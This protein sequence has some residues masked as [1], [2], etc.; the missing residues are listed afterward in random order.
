MPTQSIVQERSEQFAIRIVKMYQYLSES[1]H[2]RTISKQVLR[3]GTSIGANITEALN[4]IS[5]KDFL[6]KMYIALK[7]CKETSYWLKLL[8]K[9]G[10]MSEAEYASIEAD[11]TE[12]GKMLRSITKTTA[13]S[14]T[15]NS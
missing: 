15:P 3:S 2:E 7:E 8:H 14:L 9:T 11:C 1:R 5:R 6:A 12:L 13:A 10:Y 4:G